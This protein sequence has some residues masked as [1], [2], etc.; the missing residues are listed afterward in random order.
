MAIT[1]QTQIRLLD[2]PLEMDNNNQLT[3]SDVHAQYAYFNSLNFLEVDNASYQR[4]DNYI[5][6]PTHIDNI[7]KYN[8]CMYLNDNYTDRWFYAF[9]TNMVYVNDNL[10]Y[11]YITTDVWQ[12]WQFDI[13]F[14]QSFVEREHVLVSEDVPGAFLFPENLETGD[15]IISENYNYEDFNPVTVCA[16]SGSTIL[17]PD[18]PDNPVPL[19]QIGYSYN[20][21]Y[22]SI[23]FLLAKTPTQQQHLF[24]ML[25]FRNNSD[26]I[27]TI[28]SVPQFA[29]KSQASEGS[30]NDFIILNKN[31]YENPHTIKLGQRPSQINGYIPKNKKLL[32]YPYIYF[33]FNAPNSNRTIFHYEDFNLQ[34]NPNPSFN[35]ISEINPNPNILGIPQNFKGISNNTA[36]PISL[37]GYPTISYKNDTFNSWLA[38]NNPSM[39]LERQ[40]LQHTLLFNQVDTAYNTVK[41]LFS[42]IATLN[43]GKVVDSALNVPNQ[44]LDM[45]RNLDDFYYDISKQSAQVYQHSLLPDSVTMGSSNATQIGYNM[46]NL[47]SQYTIRQEFAKRI[48]KYFD[49][50]GYAINQLKDVNFNKRPN[51]DYIKTTGI[52]IIGGIPQEDMVTLKNIFNTGVTMWHNPA[53]FLDYSQN[54]R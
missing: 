43:I 30:G 2:L 5:R 20:G 9:I 33:A 1:P 6:F 29:V 24:R 16:F 45:V 22:S 47:F 37:T 46:L 4:K 3:F 26:Y 39:T 15:Y 21:I 13:Q 11:V 34:N 53:T 8:Y 31:I 12:T 38:Q 54:N 10:T 44:T 17:D 35:F 49:M 50:F 40:H 14:K 28:F 36:E 23:I 18:S 42:S 32:T 19:P 51:W 7:I 41:D 48:D 52:N 27:V 25:Q